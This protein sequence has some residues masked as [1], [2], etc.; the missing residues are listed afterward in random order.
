VKWL[1]ELSWPGN[2]RELKNLIERTVLVSSHDLLDVADF[3]AQFHPP[4]TSPETI[5]LPAVGTVTIEE[6][7]H[8]MILKAVDFHG[9]NI[10]RVARS[11]GLSRAAL[12][13]RLEKYDISL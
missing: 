8:S 9:R 13:R 5:T 10:S 4:Q 6:M 1:A 2:I 3:K 11:L 12:Y 7:E